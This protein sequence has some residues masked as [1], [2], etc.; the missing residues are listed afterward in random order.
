VYRPI[1][2][3]HQIGF[4]LVL[5]T[6]FALPVLAQTPTEAA[7]VENPLGLPP[8][9]PA[10]ELI[11][12][13]PA[14]PAAVSAEKQA[15]KGATSEIGP[16]GFLFKD[17]SN[18]L[19]F[20]GVVQLDGRLFLKDSSPALVDGLLVRRAMPII[21]GTLANGVSF[22][23]SPDLGQGNASISDAYGEVK[24]HTLARLRFGKFRSPVGLER[25][26]PPPQ[27]AF[28]EFSLATQ[29]TPV[30]D[31]GIQ[32]G[33][34]SAGGG[35]GYAVGLFNGAP[36]NG[37][38]DKDVSRF[39]ELGGRLYVRPLKLASVD[40]DGDLLVGF[41]GTYGKKKASPS[42]TN[43]PLPVYNT[44]G[45]NPILP[46]AS[47]TTDASANT[48]P[49]GHHIR[50]NPQLW[51]VVGPAS[52]LAEYI[53]SDQRLSQGWIGASIVNKGWAA[54]GTVFVYGGK[55][56]FTPVKIAGPFDPGA[57]TYGALELTF[58][59]S[60]LDFDNKLF[61]ALDTA[62]PNKT[63]A[64]PSK[65]VTNALETEAGISFYF[66]SNV[67]FLADYARTKFHGG[68]GTRAAVANR[69]TENLVTGRL[70]LNF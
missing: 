7:K 44:A 46:F 65:A 60:Y 47:S 40:F 45:I 41:A 43:D 56:S 32:L 14:A 13:V 55:P 36:D 21:Q 53:R 50:L 67:R 5:S 27:I 19:R 58:K 24:F 62:S 29:L 61:E 70:Q 4:G 54:T 6:V 9:A 1:R 49:N 63:L 25:L 35:L 66:N 20:N 33:G 68:A 28:P 48:A 11:V 38:N 59:V 15:P 17:G 42:G 16:N 64:D 18:T 8:A 2:P 52:L 10:P 57:G 23:I 3:I 22:L 30:R 37:Q 12:P 31:V 51:A 26:Q 34:E 69:Q 39:K